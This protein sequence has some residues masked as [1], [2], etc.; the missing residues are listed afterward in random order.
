MFV[1]RMFL[2]KTYNG[3]V[4]PPWPGDRTEFERVQ[5]ME[6]CR[7]NLIFLIDALFNGSICNGVEEQT[8]GL[9][10]TRNF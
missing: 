5:V 2:F 7:L 6:G 3:A 1:E 9:Y 10:K 8:S 4:K